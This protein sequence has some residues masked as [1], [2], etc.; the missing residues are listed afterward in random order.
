MGKGSDISRKR[1]REREREETK[2]GTESPLPTSSGQCRFVD[3]RAR[4]CLL[5]AGDLEFSESV[6][7]LTV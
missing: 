4:H 7:E 5:G 2:E 6:A 1:R 3:G